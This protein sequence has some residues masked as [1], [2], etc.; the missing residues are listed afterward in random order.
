MEITWAGIDQSPIQ[1]ARASAHSP[2]LV[3]DQIPSQIRTKKE[4]FRPRRQPRRTHRYSHHLLNLVRPCSRSA[5]CSVVFGNF[6]SKQP[7]FGESLL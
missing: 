4:E 7:A 2:F 6:A 5:I 3:D 1:T